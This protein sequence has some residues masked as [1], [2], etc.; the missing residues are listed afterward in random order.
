MPPGPLRR[1]RAERRRSLLLRPSSSFFVFSP[2]FLHER[3]RR[4]RIRDVG[5]VVRHGGQWV[6]LGPASTRR[7]GKP[8]RRRCG[9]RQHDPP[10]ARHNTPST[11]HT[12]HSHC[13][14]PSRALLR[15]RRWWCGVRCS[16]RRTKLRRRFLSVSDAFDMHG[17]G[18]NSNCSCSSRKCRIRT[19]KQ[20]PDA[21][22][23]QKYSCATGQVT[24]VYA[25]ELRR[26]KDGYRHQHHRARTWKCA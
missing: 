4:H 18:Q 7:K 14:A 15:L 2:R 13:H 1:A 3:P 16:S 9:H 21:Q 20:P 23:N 11:T 19:N 8:R 5:A 25:D 17:D 12:T 10:A 26:P 24:M 22:S 6:P